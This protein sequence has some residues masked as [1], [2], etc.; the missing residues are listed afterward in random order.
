MH[1]RNE[2]KKNNNKYKK[3]SKYNVNKFQHISSLK[4]IYSWAKIK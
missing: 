1:I 3:L 4:L 2:G